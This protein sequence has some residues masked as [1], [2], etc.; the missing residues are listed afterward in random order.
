MLLGPVSLLHCL[1]ENTA[2][3]PKTQHTDTAGDSVRLA[4][5]LAP[6][7]PSRGGGPNFASTIV[8]PVS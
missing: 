6:Y 2:L 7:H 8:L 4:E 1:L 3:I 5:T